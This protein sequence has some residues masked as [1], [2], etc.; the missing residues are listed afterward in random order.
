VGVL[1]GVL[2]QREPK[3]AGR[4]LSYWLDGLQPTVITPFHSV[5]HWPDQKFRNQAAVTDWITYTKEMHK[6][7]AR[8]LQVAG[9]ECLPILLARLT[10]KP[11]PPRATFVRRWAYAL[12]LS[13]SAPLR[14]EDYGEVRRGQALTAILLLHDRAAALVPHLSLI[15]AE[16][17]DDDAVHR[18]A[19]HALYY[20]DP[21]E[22]R[23]IR[24][25]AK[26]V[27]TDEPRDAPGVRQ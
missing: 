2:W 25:P 12:R 17:K 24:N 5:D 20:L 8:V 22:F 1:V 3:Y 7:S 26:T 6:R 13:D 19:S 21:D 23:R 15:A 4:S 18:A 10:A 27:V 11:T 16:D 14:D 9:P